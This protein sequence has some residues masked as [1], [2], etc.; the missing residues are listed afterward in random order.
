MN[1]KPYDSKT[2]LTLCILLIKRLL[3]KS[4]KYGR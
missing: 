2:Y 1:E 4:T 3:E